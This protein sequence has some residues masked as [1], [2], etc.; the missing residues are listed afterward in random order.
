MFDPKTHWENIYKTKSSKDVSWYTPHLEESFRM[1]RDLGLSKDAEIIDVGG[2]ASTLPDDLLT[3]GYKNITVLDISS[4]AI[5]VSKDR[6][7]N[8]ANLIHW[9]EADATIVSLE[10]NHYDLWHDRAVFHFL[11][12][13]EDRQKY[14]NNLGKA[15]KPGGYALIATFGPNG[16]LKCSG[17]GIVRYSAENLRQGLGETFE[18]EKHFTEIHKTPFDTTQEFLY[19]LFRKVDAFKN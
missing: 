3:E 2:G 15:L 18:L 11:T 9:L 17:L 19:C 1:I 7:G 14:V 8:K 4:E 12:K 6:L 10:P 13:P 5:K 16:P